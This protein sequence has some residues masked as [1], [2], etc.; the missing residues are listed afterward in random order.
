V[1]G[2]TVQIDWSFLEAVN[3][4][5]VAWL[6]TITLLAALI[7]KLIFRHWFWAAILAGVLFAVAY[8]FL[9]YYPHERPVPGLKTGARGALAPRSAMAPIARA[10]DRV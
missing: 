7:G 9:A 2:H 8:V 6:S 5:E 3:W 4:A 10:S 1:W